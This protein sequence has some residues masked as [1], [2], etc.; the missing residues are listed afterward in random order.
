MIQPVRIGI[1]T[2]LPSTYI[3]VWD[4]GAVFVDGKP[5]FL[6]S[7]GSAYQIANACIT[8]VSTGKRFALPLNKRAQVCAGNYIIWAVNRWYR[9]ALEL[10]TFPHATTIINILDLDEYLRGVVP[11]EMPASWHFEALKAQSIAARSYAWAHI[12]KGSKWRQQGYD[13]VPDTRDQVYKGL[14]AEAK[15]TSA[16]IAATQAIILKDADRVKPGF[17]RAWVG[18]A[19]ENLNIRQS[20]IPSPTLEKLTGVPKIL[21]VTVKQWD[22]NGNANSIEV[23]GAKKTRAVY[24]VALAHMLNFPS[25]GILDVK[26]IGSN[27]IFTYRGPGNGA[28]GLSQHGADMLAANGWNCEQI[29]R[30]YYQDPDGKLRFDLLDNYK[31]FYQMMPASRTFSRDTQNDQAN[32]TDRDTAERTVKAT[33]TDTHNK[34]VPKESA[35]D[36]SS[37]KD[38]TSNQGNSSSK[39]GISNKAD[40]SDKAIIDKTD[41]FIGK[42]DLKNETNLNG[43]DDPRSWIDSAIKDDLNIK[44]KTSITDDR[45]NTG[46]LVEKAAGKC[47]DKTE[48]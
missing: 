16:A 36:N 17:F 28:R 1:A 35:E 32:W 38:D 12:G 10:I 46:N 9:G 23:I 26:Q 20:V 37:D 29:L 41:N 47:K 39:E 11:A 7:P 22:Q 6:L 30:Q 40:S 18:D 13:L 31:S 2:R 25:A 27:W 3:A 45:D 15:S 48:D 42:G 44:E 8:E 19:F 33:V 14:A 24:G 34:T 21:G 5:V 4:K 43:R